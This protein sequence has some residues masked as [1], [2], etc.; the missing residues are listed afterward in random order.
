MSMTTAD[1]KISEVH[2]Q[3]FS[4]FLPNNEEKIGST[5]VHVQPISRFDFGYQNPRFSI[6]RAGLSSSLT[7]RDQPMYLRC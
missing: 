1:F 4:S 3:G 2:E 7:Q 5:C 6:H